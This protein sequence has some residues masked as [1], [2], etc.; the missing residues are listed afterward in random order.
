MERQLGQSDVT[1]PALG[2]GTNR[3]GGG[4]V[5]AET[6]QK[7]YRAALDAGVGFFDTAEIYT[8][9]G[10]N[11][12]SVRRRVTTGALLFWPPSSHRSRTA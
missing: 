10:P 12:P 3:W 9:V 11:S 8:A 1:V 7:A 4:A 5:D 6:L 2:V